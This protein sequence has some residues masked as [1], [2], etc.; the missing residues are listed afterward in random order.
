MQS[1]LG[2]VAQEV[3]FTTFGRANL[4]SRMK[5]I[6]RKKLFL[7]AIL[8]CFSVLTNV[9]NVF[10][11][12]NLTLLSHLTFAPGVTCAGVWYYVDSLNRE[13]AL[14]GTSVGTAIV[15][16]TNPANPNLLFLIPGNASNWREVKT[17]GKYA[18]MI[19]EGVDLIDSTKNGLQIINL[20]YLPDSVPSKIWRGDGAIFN[21]L[22][23][24]HTLTIDDGYVYISGS[25]LANGGVVIA[26]LSD[27][28]NP[29][30]VGQ[31]N[32]E[33]VH[34]CFVRGTKMWTSEMIAGQ[35]SVINI[36]D[37]SNPVTIVDQQTPYQFNHN[38]WLSD[39]DKYFFTIDE[40][41]HAPVCAFDVSNLLNIS[42]VGT[43]RCMNMDT[44]EVHNVRFFND[45]LICPAYGSQVTI[46]DVKRP[47]NMVEVANFTTGNGLCWD[48][49]PFLPSG[50]ILATDKTNGLFV[51]SPTY[52]RA[53]YLEGSVKDS[54]SGLIIND[55][56]VEIL[57]TP[58]ATLSDFYGNYKT[59]T[60]EEGTYCVQVSAHA[61]STKVIRNVILKTG[62]VTELN[63]VLSF[64]NSSLECEEAVE[65]SGVFP[66]PV[67]SKATIRF[68]GL[69]P[70][71]EN[72]FVLYD[73][74][75][76]KI[77][78]TIIPGSNEFV[79]ERKSLSGGMY[80]YRVM[81]GS[82]IFSVGKLIIG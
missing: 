42:L 58:V 6:E 81:T 4:L 45:Y 49:I 15:D 64:D 72:I 36:T 75:G 8:I 38:G 13:Y 23:D 76:K 66:N 59:G 79:F 9:R 44:L 11:Q 74:M 21:Q 51:L 78:E 34:D 18:Y 40:V 19:T 68:N 32:S 62:E 60:T 43:Y 77:S 35:F 20:S 47:V 67:S 16:V 3:F 31:Y 14:V 53:C 41:H 71:A 29:H 10:A 1:F 52:V 54:T 50:N 70:S 57:S 2:K 39:D 46:V 61:F 17:L 26:S 27:P 73:V 33:Y 48:A 80:F 30:Y 12:K 5:T 69:N 22:S 55:A 63:V 25:N 65:N 28:W 24:A 82:N 37:R 56:Q 7:T